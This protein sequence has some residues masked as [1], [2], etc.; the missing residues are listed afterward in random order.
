MLM[1]ARHSDIDSRQFVDREYYP[2]RTKLHALSF[3]ARYYPLSYSIRTISEDYHSFSCRHFTGISNSL[4]SIYTKK[5]TELD[6]LECRL[7]IW[8]IFALLISL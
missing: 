7:N 8:G 1:W 6:G 5:R 4:E 2:T 3:L